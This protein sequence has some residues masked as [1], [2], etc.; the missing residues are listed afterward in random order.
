MTRFRPSSL[1][2]FI[3]TILAHKARG[4]SR[5]LSAF[6][7]EGRG[8]ARHGY[9]IYE[10]AEG[11]GPVGVVTSG[12][13]GPTVGKNIGLGYVPLHLSAPGAPLYVDCRGKRVPAQVVRAP[14]YKRPA[15]AA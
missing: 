10:G 12:S 5:R 15:H 6:V 14:F 8:T 11:T 2:A 9:A 1:I 7:M 3:D 4:L 13:I